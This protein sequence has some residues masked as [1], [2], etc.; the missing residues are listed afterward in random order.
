MSSLRDIWLDVPQARSPASSAVPGA[1]K[2]DAAADGEQAGTPS[3]GQV[4]VNGHDV[5]AAIGRRPA[6]RIRRGQDDLP[7][8]NLLASRTVAGKHR[9]A[10]GDRRRQ[11]PPTS[12]PAW[13]ADRARRPDRAGG[14]LSGG[15]VGRPETARRHRP[16]SPPAARFGT[17]PPRRLT[18]KPPGVLALAKDI[19]RERPDHPADPEMDV[20]TIC[21]HVAVIEAGRISSRARTS[22]ARPRHLILGVTGVAVPQ[23]LASPPKPRRAAGRWCAPSLARRHRP[24]AG[25]PD[26]RTR[27]QRQ[28]PCRRH[29][30]N[31]REARFGSLIVDLRSQARRKIG[32]FSGRTRTYDRGAWLCRL[33]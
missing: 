4:I 15:T 17:R 21:S 28:Y 32:S 25:A 26:R 33:T 6:R 31:R 30:V 3:S 20:V 16:R 10:A 19:N 23:S 24:D 2:S 11:D 27:R 9:A 5:G 29:R 8:F 18:P 7:A 13:R 1:G 14:P 12:P 22:R